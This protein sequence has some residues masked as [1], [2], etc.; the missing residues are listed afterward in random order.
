[1]GC[2]MY[3]MLDI[4]L[5]FSGIRHCISVQYSWELNSCDDRA[6]ISWGCNIP[7]YLIGCNISTAAFLVNTGL[8][9]N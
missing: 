6:R 8:T 9:V 5:I 1:M 2:R 7:P 4:L 3:A